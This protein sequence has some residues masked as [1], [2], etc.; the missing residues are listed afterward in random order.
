MGYLLANVEPI[1][2]TPA[3]L[4]SVDPPKRELPDPAPPE[5][6][7]PD[8]E[9]SDDENRTDSTKK[10]GDNENGYVEVPEDWITFYDED[11]PGS[12][13]YCNS[14]GTQIVTLRTY[15]TSTEYDPKTMA[16]AIY[17]KFEAENY[18]GIES[19]IAYD[20]QDYTAYKVYG[21]EPNSR[22]LII[23]WFFE[24]ENGIAHFLSIEG[25]I[26]DTPKEVFYIPETFTL[27]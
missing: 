1:T 5:N 12:T 26:S 16:S 18:L 13:Q 11:A 6:E 23:I 25:P 20:I 3:P 24:D 14:T 21:I 9:D 19:A 4:E 7:T 10:V 17:A 27:K 2:E 22:T 15:G 8:D